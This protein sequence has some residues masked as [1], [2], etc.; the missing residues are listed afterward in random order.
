MRRLV[1]IL[2]LLF[3]P[4]MAFAQHEE[5]HAE[6]YFGFV[7][8]WVLKTLN[9]LLF[10]GVLVYFVGGPVKKA[11]RDRG[12]QIRK[13]SD[14]ARD[15]REKAD[16]MA[17][18]IQARLEQIAEDVR[19]IHERAEAEGERQKRE[20]VAAA[21]AEA[22]KILAAARTEV[23]NRLKNARAELTEFA[24]RLAA[25]RAEEILRER[26]TES[27]QQKLFQESLEQVSEVGS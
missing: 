8:G 14:E 3:L 12:D 20:L 1:V 2:I 16:R 17:A 10:I 15:R 13:A 24:G 5:G 18:D 7:P 26:I 19:S 4:V 27:D 9:M 11:F 6:V 21:E 23:D 22:A 25:N